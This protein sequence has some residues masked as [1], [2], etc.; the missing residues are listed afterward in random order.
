MNNEKA[1]IGPSS[2]SFEGVVWSKIGWG[3]VA[4]IA[5]A[6]LTYLTALIPTLDFGST[7]TP[8]VMVVWTTIANIVRKWVSQHE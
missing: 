1:I 4:A 7:W 5:G 8:L 6:V 3:L 2:F